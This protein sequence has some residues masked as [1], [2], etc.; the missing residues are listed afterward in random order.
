MWYPPISRTQELD[1]ELAKLAETPDDQLGEIDD[2]LIKTSVNIRQLALNHL[3]PP[4]H[5]RDWIWIGSQFRLSAGDRSPAW[6]VC[7]GALIFLN[8]NIHQAGTAMEQFQ[9]DFNWVADKTVSELI[10]LNGARSYDQFLSPAELDAVEVR[11]AEL[12]HDTDNLS[13]HESDGIAEYTAWLSNISSETYLPGIAQMVDEIRIHVDAPNP[14][15]RSSAIA[16]LR[17]VLEKQ[18]VVPD[19]LGYLGLVDDIYAIEVTFRNLNHQNAFRP[20]VEWLSVEQPSLARISFQHSRNAIRFDQYL[21]AVFGLSLIGD[22]GQSNRKCL[23]LPETSIC[24]LIGA[25]LAAVQSIRTQ[26]TTRDESVSFSP[27]DDMILSDASVVIAARYSGTLEHAGVSY[28]TVEIR[29]GRRTI[30]DLELASAAK[31]PTAHRN[32]STEKDF[33][34]WRKTH[35]PLA[36]L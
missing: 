33:G 8:K 35:E 18:D 28:H 17:Y 23:V 11:L 19:G 2:F 5:L 15:H 31:S 36:K 21:Q 32:L 20:L 7:K 9:T 24:G 26:I 13:T 30:T 25:F 27:G 34:A 12:R 1:A 3:I 10:G 14:V 22:T 4:S 16:C 29:D 6:P